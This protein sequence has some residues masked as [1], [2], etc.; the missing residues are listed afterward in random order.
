MLKENAIILEGLSTYVILVEEEVILSK[1][2]LVIESDSSEVIV[3]L[4]H[5]SEDPSKISLIVDEIGKLVPAANMIAISKC[6]RLENQKSSLLGTRI[7]FEWKFF[8]SFFWAQL[9]PI[10][11]IF[12]FGWF[13]PTWFSSILKEEFGV[14]VG[15]L[16]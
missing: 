12:F 14:P 3:T 10:F 4:N 7:S 8:F 11:G 16:L 6:S 5:E 1:Q 15:F 9:V 13:F 2:P